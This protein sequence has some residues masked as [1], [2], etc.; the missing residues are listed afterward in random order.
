MERRPSGSP[1]S[2][3]GLGTGG[4]GVDGEGGRLV[5]CLARGEVYQEEEMT[6]VDAGLSVCSGG[7]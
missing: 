6:D 3:V 5:S 2:E 1:L 4:A 7:E